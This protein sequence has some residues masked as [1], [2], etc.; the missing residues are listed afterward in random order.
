MFDPCLHIIVR[1][2]T[3]NWRT[4]IACRRTT[5]RRVRSHSQQQSRTDNTGG[6][7]AF[8]DTREPN[9]YLEIR[10]HDKIEHCFSKM[11]CSYI[12]MKYMHWPAARH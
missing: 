4:S 5:I 11:A 3:K 9:A 6:L 7:T 2:D 8:V 10:N 12:Y 1:A